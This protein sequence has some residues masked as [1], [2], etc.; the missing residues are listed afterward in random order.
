[1]D[2][3]YYSSVVQL[4]AT[5][6]LLIGLLISNAQTVFNA[7]N[8]A[9]Y[10]I[11]MLIELMVL[12]MLFSTIF[13]VLFL[14]AMWEKDELGDES[15]KVFNI[16]ILVNSFFIP[17]V[18]ALFGVIWTIRTEDKYI[19]GGLSLN[20][21]CISHSIEVIYYMIMLTFAVFGT[22]LQIRRKCR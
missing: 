19:S 1:M 16:M 8:D 10:V 13:T 7:E 20:S 9:I 4:T 2:K 5:I 3:Q 18:L 22:G 14:F 15:Y 6:I 21:R 12:A 17:V 11:S